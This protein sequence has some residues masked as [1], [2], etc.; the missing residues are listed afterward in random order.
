MFFFGFGGAWLALWAYGEY[1]LQPAVLSLIA[2]CT[3]ALFARA[4]LVHRSNAPALLDI[5]NTPEERRKRK[6]FNYINV[7]QWAL[8]LVIGNVLSN[9]GLRDFVLPAAM[10]VIGLHFL[11]L[12]RLFAYPPHFV[13]GAALMALAIAYPLLAPSGP[14]SG[15]G[16][17]GAGLILWCSAAWA[18][19][20]ER[21][22]RL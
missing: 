12:A 16:P 11:P 5:A 7:A 15:L 4:W 17:L 6:L 2:A 13:T 3:L 22:L 1:G 19:R 21:P 9:I 8:I 18:I 14:R 10:L 20:L